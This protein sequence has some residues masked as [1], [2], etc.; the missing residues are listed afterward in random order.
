MFKTLSQSLVLR[1]CMETNEENVFIDQKAERDQFDKF[2]P[3]ITFLLV[4]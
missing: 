2:V 1:K 3:L 4:N